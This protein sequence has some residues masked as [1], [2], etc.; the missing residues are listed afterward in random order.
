MTPTGRTVGWL[1]RDR[2]AT[3]SLRTQLLVMINVPLAVLVAVFLV[4]DFRREMTDRMREKRIALEEEAKTILPAVLQSRPG[5]ISDV[6]AYIDSVCAQMRNTDSPG[7]HIAVSLSNLVLQATSHHRASPEMFEALR[8]GAESPAGRSRIQD[9]EIIVGVCRVGDAAVFVSEELVPI[10]RAAWR[11]LTR[12]LVG[13]LI[14]AGI[15]AGML[16]IVLLRIVTAPLG[17]LVDGVRQIA[18]GKLGVQIDAASSAELRFLSDEVNAMSRALAE[19]DRYRAFQMAKARQ[20]QQHVLPSR[21]SIAGLT[22]S[23][24]FAPADEVGGDYYDVMPHSDHRVLICVADVTGHGVAAAMTTM[25]LRALVHTAAELYDS[26][27]EIVQLVNRQF[28]DAT[29]PGDFA[30]L[31]LAEID[32]EKQQLE[33]V[34]AG[35]ETCVLV[36][37]EGPPQPLESTGLI[38]GIDKHAEFETRRLGCGPGDRLLLVTD[39]VTETQAAEGPMFGRNRMVDLLMESRELPIDAITTR[40][41]RE[42]VDFRHGAPPHDDIT[43]VLVEIGSNGPLATNRDRAS[44]GRNEGLH[45]LGDLGVGDAV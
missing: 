22:I 40:L 21:R 13:L 24:M 26:P 12:R 27:L 30:T 6:Q 38:L 31:I 19:A 8:R 34:S 39:G 17:R 18:S 2:F 4:Y 10:R 14:L 15:A 9:H 45:P 42:L 33:Y 35:H 23:S 20:I 25:L 16:N 44:L 7:H 32:L 3:L 36:R 41:N 28:V 37:R 11:D 43:I 29:L 1:D 5:G